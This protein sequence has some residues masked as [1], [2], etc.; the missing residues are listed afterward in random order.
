MQLVS[1]ETPGITGP[2]ELPDSSSLR[3]M[4]LAVSAP[5]SGLAVGEPLADAERIDR[6]SALEDLKAAAAAAQA[7]L[8]AELD[9]SRRAQEEA[10]GVP[11][12]ERGRG[13]AAEVALARH[14][15]PHAGGKLLGL[16]K[17]LV[18]EMPHT[19]AA[20]RSGA[21]SEWRATLLVRETACLTR[22]D[23]TEVD[24]E[25]AGTEEAAAELGRMGTRAIVAA[26]RRVAYRLDAQAVVDRSAR[27]ADDRYVS[28][29]P[30][31]DCMAVLTTLLP[32]AQGVAA[33]AALKAEA[34]TARAAGDPRTG[35]QVMA[36]ALV[37]RLTGQETAEQVPVCVN[38]VMDADALLGTGACTADLN[39]R[40]AGTAGPIPAAVA[41][42]ILG[43][44]P[45]HGRWIRRLFTRPSTGQLVAAESRQRCFPAG[46][47][48]VVALVQPTCRSAWCDAPVVQTDHVRDRADG[49]ATALHNAQGLCQACNL[50]KSLPGWRAS[51]I[52]EGNGPP[53][54][55]VTRTPTGHEYRS[56]GGP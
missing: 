54:A 29:R 6:L 12:P 44:A 19:L 53:V 28:L 45:E 56:G 48:E 41:A 40:G 31:P 30:A 55:V 16:G 3:L 27:A 34:D 21:V 50:T 14:E 2:S 32:V 10:R 39:A 35:G 11:A 42:R 24:R 47:A 17:A 4:T 20:L 51:P 5:D 23:R 37:T 26:A 8:A 49:G 43:A 25:L 9:L 15:S 36:D 33:Y 38:L 7:V 13:V 22:E 52:G 1:P 46:I 18:R